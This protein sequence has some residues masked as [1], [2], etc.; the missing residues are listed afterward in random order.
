MAEGESLESILSKFDGMIEKRKG[1]AKMVAR[2]QITTFNSL[3]TKAR[4]KNLGIDT[5]VWLTSE[6]ERVRPAHAARNGKEFT[7]SD[8]LHSSI[9]GKTLLPGVDYQCRCD[10]RLIIP[11]MGEK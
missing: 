6:D 8:G 1:H 10:Y 11:K 5:A 4:A 3:T 9:D 7:L 2:T